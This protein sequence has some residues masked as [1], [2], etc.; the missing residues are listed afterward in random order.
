MLN[1]SITV[2]NIRPIEMADFEASVDTQ[3]PSV[4]EDRIKEHEEW[5]KRFGQRG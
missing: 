4:C 1:M 2:E 3:R 5:A